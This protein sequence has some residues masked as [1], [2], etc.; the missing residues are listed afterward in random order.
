MTKFNALETDVQLS[1]VIPTFN[2][3]AM[4]ERTLPTILEQSLS[5]AHYEVIVVVDGSI[6]G[7]SELLRH[8]EAGHR[9]RFIEQSNRGQAA[10]RN[11]G[12]ALARG[13]L[14]LFLDDDLLCARV[15]LEEHLAVQEASDDL[16]L[17]FGPVLVAPESRHGL[18]TAWLRADAEMTMARRRRRRPVEGLMDV[19]VYPNSSVDRD[20]LLECGGFDEQFL[21]AGE[22]TELGLR[23]WKRGINFRF[24]LAAR[25]EEIYTKTAWGIV[26]REAPQ[27]GRNEV[28]LYERHPEFRRRTVLARLPEGSS[29]KRLARRALGCA[30]GAATPLCAIGVGVA[31]VL[32]RI[33]RA[34][35]AAIKVFRS[36]RGAAMFAAAVQ[37]VGSWRN[38]RTEFAARLP[39]LAYHHVGPP[40]PGDDRR[41]T[42]TPQ[43][44]ERHVRALARMKYVGIRPRD[45]L[46]WRDGRCGIPEKPVH[47]TF[48]DGYADVVKYALPILE[49]YQYAATL[50][51]VSGEIGASNSWEPQMALRRELADRAGLREWLKAGMEVGSHTRTHPDLTTLESTEMEREVRGSRDELEA[52]TKH[53]VYAFSYPYGA[54]NDAVVAEVSKAFPV[55]FTAETGVNDIRTDAL[56]LR[57]VVVHGDETSFD[58]LWRLRFGRRPFQRA[59]SCLRVR[60]RMHGFHLFRHRVMS[61]RD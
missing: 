54:Y 31:E 57:R 35:R 15:L 23:L 29:V 1:V 59:R 33:P 61:H 52:L 49:R 42:I 8:Y 22:D 48:D 7:T 24:A 46:T 17:V 25:T 39:V 34:E 27:Y 11:A 45:W 10:A 28:R 32:W 3:R 56:L 30:P 12:L 50:F 55:G 36:S 37:E 6:D 41:F 58:L 51:A 60:T 16:A 53:V 18:A 40:E 21:R 44:F 2:R 13:S 43:R 4:L 20:L 19:T 5:R 26:R 47:L 14:V 9:L 38:V